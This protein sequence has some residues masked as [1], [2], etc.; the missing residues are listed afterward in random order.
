MQ[1]LFGKLKYY[2][3][4]DNFFK[5]IVNK[6]KLITDGANNIKEVEASLYERAIEDKTSKKHCMY[7]NTKF[8]KGKTIKIFINKA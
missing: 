8:K 4:D 3:L 1:T 2:P 5:E 7:F 6:L